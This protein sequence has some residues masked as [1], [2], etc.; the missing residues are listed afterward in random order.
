MKKKNDSNNSYKLQLR[1]NY[2]FYPT[3]ACLK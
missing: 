2:E 1:N 3:L